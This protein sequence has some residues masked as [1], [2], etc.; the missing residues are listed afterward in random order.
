MRRLAALFVMTLAVP[1]WAQATARSTAAQRQDV[2][3]TV[4][5]QGF[6]LVREVRD[7]DM[8]QGRVMLE[9][10]DV[11]EQIQPETVAIKAPGLRVLEQN[12]RYDLLSPQK[13]LDKYVGKK[14]KVVRYND[15]TGHDE[16]TEAE[17]LSTTGGTVLKI[18]GEITY[19][20]PGRISFPSVPDNLIA[21]PTLVW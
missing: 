4:Y 11:S 1:A 21:R 16:E 9:F 20:Y 5:N 14:V 6:G 2:S 7:V 8:S 18:G 3:I 13:L 10:R 12:Y 17:V 15:K 19:G